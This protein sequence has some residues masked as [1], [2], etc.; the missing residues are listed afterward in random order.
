[1]TLTALPMTS[2]GRFSPLGPVGIFDQQLD[3]WPRIIT[4]NGQRDMSDPLNPG[5]LTLVFPSAKIT[6]SSPTWGTISNWAFMPPL[7]SQ[8]SHHT[9]AQAPCVASSIP[10]DIGARRRTVKPVKFQTETLPNGVDRTVDVD[11]DTRHGPSAASSA[12]GRALPSGAEN[13]A[14]SN[15]G[16]GDVP[17]LLE[18][19]DD[20][21][22]EWLLELWEAAPTPEQGEPSAATQLPATSCLGA[23]WTPAA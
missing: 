5:M 6:I 12:V 2:A 11:G 19:E 20:L 7:S 15:A 22:A 4:V 1:M 16:R 3:T 14:R 18:L 8:T 13:A 21:G 23:F 9:I 17:A 10:R